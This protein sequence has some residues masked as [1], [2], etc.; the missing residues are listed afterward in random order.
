MRCRTCSRTSADARAG[1]RHATHARASSRASSTST[2]IKKPKLREV[3]GG[4]PRRRSGAFGFDFFAVNHSIPDA[5]RRVHPHAGGQRPAHRRLQARPDAR[6]TDA[7]TDY[8]ALAQVRRSRASTLCSVGL[9]QRRDARACTRSEAEVGE[10]APRHHRRRR[11]ARHRRLVREPHPPRAAGLRRRGRRGPQ[12]RRHRPLDGQQ[13]Q[14]RPRPR[15]PRDRRRRHRRRVSMPTACPPRRSSSCAPAARASRSR[16]SRAWPTAT[17]ARSRVE[18]GDTVVISATP[19]PGNEKAVEP[20]HQPARQGR[21]DRACTRAR[22]TCTSRGTPPPR[23]SSSCST[24]SSRSSSCR[25]TARRGTCAAHARLAESVGIPHENIFVL[26]NGDVPRDRRGGRPP[27]RARSSSGVVYV[28]G[29]GVGDVGT[30]R[31]ARPAAPGQDGIATVVIAI[32]AQTGKADRRARTRDARHR[33][34]A[35]TR[36][37]CSTRRAQRI[38]KTLAKT[39]KEG[40][41]DHRGHQERASASRSRSSCGSACAAGR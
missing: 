1:S 20:R 21:R 30:G 2:S 37:S 9:H 4:R 39:G 38:A 3:Q 10:V 14:D 24:S 7:L 18:E 33:A 19:V 6:S 8:G 12:G 25:S 16:R 40:A 41:T 22:P 5:R 23:S 31:A 17:T 28:D 35:P 15:L 32:D 11:A 13:H 27:S 36:T 34:S 29:L 26:D